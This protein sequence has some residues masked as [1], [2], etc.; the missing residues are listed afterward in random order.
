MTVDYQYQIGGSLPQDAPTYVVR[1]ADS[2]LYQ[3]LK[4]GEFC[5]VLNSRQM[6]KSSLLVRTVQKLSA[7]R[8]A[9]ATIDLSDIG[10]QQV[11]LDKWY[12][13][14]AYKLLCSFN[15]FDAAEFMAWWRERELMSPVQRLGELIEELLLVKISQNIVIF[16]DEIDSVL[17]FKESLDDFFALIRSCYNKRAH[18]SEYQRLTFAFLGVATP[19]DLISDATRTPFNI[20]RAIELQGF[21]LHESGSLVKGFEGKFDNSQAVLRE[22]LEWTGGQPFLTQKLCKLIVQRQELGRRTEVLATNQLSIAEIVQSQIIDNWEAADEPVHLKTIRDRL[23]RNQHRA[24]RLLGLY[25][26]ILNPPQPPLTKGGQVH[27]LSQKILNP[28]QPPLTKGG[29]V[30]TSFSPPYQGG[31]GGGTA[32]DTSEETE[33][34]LSGLVIKQAGKLT[35][36]NRIYAAIFNQNWV[37]KALCDLRPYAESLTAWIASNCQDES[38]L[39]HGQALQSAREWAAGKSLCTQDYQFLAAS[40]EAEFAQ[41]CDRQQQTQAE[42]ELLRRENQLLEQLSAEQKL[43]KVTQLKLWR[44]ERLKV[45]IFT[46]SSVLMISL[47]IA[48]FWIEPSIEE[49][50]NKILTLSLF[51]ETLFAADKKPEALI[52]SIKAVRE[53]QRSLGVASDIQVRVLTALEQAVYSFNKRI[54]FAASTTKL[55]SLAFSPD[56]QMLLTVGEDRTLKIW[57]KNGNL[58]S[59]LKGHSH[60]IVNVSFSPDSQRLASVSEDNTVK[61]WQVDGKLIQTFKVDSG[62]VTGVSFSQNDRIIASVINEGNALMQNLNDRKIVRWSQDKCFVTNVSCSRDG[63]ILASVCADGTVKLADLTNILANLSSQQAKEVSI[64]GNLLA[65]LKVENDTITSTSFSFDGTTLAIAGTGQNAIIWSKDGKLLSILKHPS[66]VTNVSF[67]PDGQMLLSASKDKMLRLWKIDGTLLK[68]LTG[69]TAAVWSA[70]FSPDG[71]AIASASA[72]GTVMLWNLNL[73]DLLVRG[74]NVARNYF[75]TNAIANS[76]NRHLCDGIESRS[77]SRF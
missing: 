70:S 44:E 22:I 57:H 52:E 14:V 12:G 56:S 40:Q 65:N 49:R 5:Y 68:T 21:K 20:G 32:D 24:S 17:S 77:D 16:I 72:D 23:L 69:N 74:C 36:S 53:M 58:K 19:S 50:N 67:S 29:Q 63:K 30:H 47:L 71:K 13:G 33:L 25:Q 59:V 39:L 2:E 46:V 75:Q 31:A 4:A 51:S 55:S 34:R 48:A 1:Q 62:K 73:D 41:L 3:A 7:D 27:T 45:Q 76:S 37:E 8:I 35:V 42:I 26:K 43:R 66:Q 10:S 64:A 54:I 6:G 18:K 9:C 11:S 15:L 61:L 60:R 28:P 38:R